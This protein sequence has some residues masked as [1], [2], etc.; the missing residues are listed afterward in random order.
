[1]TCYPFPNFY[2][3]DLFSYGWGHSLSDKWKLGASTTALI[4]KSQNHLIYLEHQSLGEES[5]G[6]HYKLSKIKKTALVEK[7]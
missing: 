6:I 5:L 2:F 7:S 3:V 1:M 4:V